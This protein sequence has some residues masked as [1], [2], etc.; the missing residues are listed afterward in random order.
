MSGIKVVNKVTVYEHNG[1]EVDGGA[2]E[3]NSHWNR[4]EFVVIFLP[5]DK[6]SKKG[7]SFTVSARDLEAAIKN[8]TNTAWP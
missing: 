5:S 4:R 8:A 7:E 1:K 2:I 3:V 6:D